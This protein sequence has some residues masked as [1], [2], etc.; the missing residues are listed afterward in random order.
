MRGI[1]VV[2]VVDHTTMHSSTLTSSLEGQVQFAERVGGRKKTVDYNMQD[3]NC[4]IVVWLY[5][6]RDR[7]YALSF[8]FKTK[9]ILLITCCLGNYR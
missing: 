5:Y 3:D 6:V 7:Y 4:N 1:T 8:K 2:I 9:K